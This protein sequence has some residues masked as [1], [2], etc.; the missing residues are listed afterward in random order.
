MYPRLLL[1]VSVSLLLGLVVPGRAQ[2]DEGM[3]PLNMAP[4]K[5]IRAK[6]EVELND[7]WLEH[8]MRASLRFNNGG[9]GSFVSGQGLVLTNHHVGSECIQQL[10]TR[11]GADDLMKKGFVAKTHADELE[12][13]DLE[14]NAL[15]SIE[16]VTARI[17]AAANVKSSAREK[18]LARKAEMA[19]I[20]K[21]CTKKTGLRCDVVTL[22]SGGAYHLY[23]YQRYTDVRLVFAPEL[24]IAFFGGDRDNFTYPRYCLDAALF[25]VYENGKPTEVKDHFRLS[26]TGPS[27]GDPIFLSGN[28]G[29]TDRFAPVAKLE[30]LEKTAYPFILDRLK[31]E[32]ARLKAFAAKGKRQAKAARDEL[33]GV[34]NSIKAL[35]GYLGGLEDKALM[36][37]ARKREVHLIGKV[38]KLEDKALRARLLEAWPKLETAYKAHAKF[39]RAHAVLERWLAPGGRLASIAKHLIR[40][41]I[42]QEK[43]NEDRLKEYRDSNRESLELSLFSTAPIDRDLEVELVAIGLENI[44]TVLGP[45]DPLVDKLLGKK[46]P[47]QRAELAVRKSKLDDV[48]LRKKLFRGGNKALAKVDDPMLTLVRIYE[49][50]AR[51]L[52]KRYEDEVES[53][54]RI[55]SGRIAEAY[56]AAFG[57][58]IYPDATFTLRLNY[59]QVRGYREAGKPVPWHTTFG[60]LFQRHATAKG[61]APYELPK[62][63][64]DARDAIDASTPLNFVTTNDIIGGNSGSPMLSAGGE[65]VGLV[66][67]GNIHQ[68]PNRFLYRE[69]QARSIG[70]DSRAILHALTKVYG[71]AHLA[72]ELTGRPAP[73]G[74]R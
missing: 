55:Y 1:A 17:E 46:T 31:F 62:R 35:T 38:R 65:V 19:K 36:D 34:E 47:R 71:A 50:Q 54:E 49:S 42:E 8:V 12:C 67:D 57:S 6:Y 58:S 59:G 40:N 29:S 26:T 39:Y 51:A 24:G 73:S 64:L 27:E 16:D 5:A 9:S 23:R 63:W 22:Y 37:E 7:A 56:N 14:L 18:N 74:G 10:S 66:F 43:K 3:W 41:A 68:L 60:G 28:P 11:E 69:E 52:R 45:K 53:I 25:R 20:E 32:R 33:F 61:K 30:L 13:P 44:R 21:I 2:A 72:A 48:A 70:V 15:R 4:T